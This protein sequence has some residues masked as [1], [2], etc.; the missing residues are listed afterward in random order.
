MLTYLTAFFPFS[1]QP[2]HVSSALDISTSSSSIQKLAKLLP[3]S[4]FIA[5]P[6]L[7]GPEVA[8]IFDPGLLSTAYAGKCYL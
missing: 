2:A 4:S 3:N 5:T 6:Q 8:K 7:N 1:P